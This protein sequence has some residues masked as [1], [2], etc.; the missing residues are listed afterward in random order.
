MPQSTSIKLNIAQNKESFKLEPIS[1]QAPIFKFSY[2]KKTLGPIQENPENPRTCL[3]T[4]LV[5]GYT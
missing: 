3:V 4:C 2:L 1:E 5:R